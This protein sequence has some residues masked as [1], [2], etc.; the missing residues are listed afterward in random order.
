MEDDNLM[1]KL[2]V[3]YCTEVVF[4][5]LDSNAWVSL[6]EVWIVSQLL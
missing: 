4:S 2:M 1:Q 5:Y 3:N 6:C